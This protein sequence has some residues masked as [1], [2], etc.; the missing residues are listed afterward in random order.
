MDK[1]I[2]LGASTVKLNTKNLD[3]IQRSLKT[4]FV[5]RVGVLGPKATGRTI[6]E[7]KHFVGSPDG[8]I[9]PVTYPST[10]SNA[11][12]GIIHEKGSISAGIPRR[13]FIEMPLTTKMPWVM[14]KLGQQWIDALTKTNIKGMV[15]KLGIMG[16]KV[17]QTAFATRGFG[18]W[19]PNTQQTIARKGSDMPLID[20]AQL[21]K[22]ISS[23]VVSK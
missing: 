1:V 8:G 16:E 15:K 19:A 20:S 9:T 10:M 5:A 23:D 13:S 4:N 6:T 18:R 21:R 17:I 11:D 22:S 12:I 2:K 3:A 14:K 7:R